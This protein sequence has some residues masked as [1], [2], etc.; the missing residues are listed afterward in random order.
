MDFS[1]GVRKFSLE[2][3]SKLEDMQAEQEV[4]IKAFLKEKL[5]DEYKDL[6][7]IRFD[8]EAAKFYAAEGTE[9]VIRKL[10]DAGYL[11]D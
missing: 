9:S 11:K 2:A 8:N 3:K 10:R 4:R 7:S 5:G 6:T 1:E